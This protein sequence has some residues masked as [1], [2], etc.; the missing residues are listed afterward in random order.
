MGAQSSLIEELEQSIAKG[1]SDQR[2]ETLRRITNLFVVSAERINDQQA[3]VFDDVMGRLIEVIETRARAELSE[4]LAPMPNA[5]CGVIR[6]LAHDDEISVAGPVLTQSPRLTESDLVGIAET[7]SQAHL[8]AISGRRSIDQAV[9][10]VLV[11][12]GD[13]GVVR[14]VVG[15][16]GAS[17]SDSGFG[18]LV[19]RANKDD[20]ISDRLVQRSD[21]PP[22]LFCSLL[23]QATEAVRKRLLALAPPEVQPDVYRVV[24]R[25]SEE[26]AAGSRA[27]IQRDYA[28]A[29][30]RL[31]SKYRAGRLGEP[32]VIQFA[33]ADQFE[34]AVAALS[35]LSNV[36]VDVIEPVLNGDRI[37]PTLI[38]CKAAG[39]QWPTAR[40]VVLLRSRGRQRS[41]ENLADA[42]ADFDKLSVLTAQ[43]VTR[44][45]QSRAA[46]H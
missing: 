1:T 14:K 25:V 46:S 37:E 36:P 33:Q 11:D 9:T 3:E 23:V 4:R 27:G 15:N 5:P 10:D 17:F 28:G 26:L 40:A 20:V 2:A 43:Q 42:Q 35:L 22:H 6:R 30:R 45:W 16:P 41:S 18:A 34:E 24:A 39:F 12:R 8:L 19:Q 7:K 29:I 38:L 32:E 21:I 13:D 31:L 44:F